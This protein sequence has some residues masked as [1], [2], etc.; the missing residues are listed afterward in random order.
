M[1]GPET[2]APDYL[3]PVIG[4]RVWRATQTAEG[5]ALQSA[6]RNQ[7]WPHGRH[8][9]ALC[10][11]FKL[12]W[13]QRHEAPQEH[14]DCGVHAL[15]LDQL[16]QEY[17]R[18]QAPGLYFPVLG[19]VALWGKVVVTENGWRGQFAYPQQL[20]VPELDRRRHVARRLA[21]SL[22][23]YGVPVHVLETPVDRLDGDYSELR[24]LSESAGV[25]RGT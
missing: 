16:A 2:R 7:A 21:E 1:Q 12:P 10:N 20:F 4:W 14:C 5:V 25:T 8:L 22:V 9:G 6:F 13:R 24:R 19:A 3:E 17:A 23:G 11:A 15:K 18:L